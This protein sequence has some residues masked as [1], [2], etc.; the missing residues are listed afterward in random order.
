M[1]KSKFGYVSRAEN[2]ALGHLDKWLKKKKAKEN[3]DASKRV[4][5]CQSEAIRKEP[6]K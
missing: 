4:A 5:N 1:F 3:R 2:E 6:K